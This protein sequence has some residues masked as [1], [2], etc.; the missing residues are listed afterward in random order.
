MVIPRKRR[1]LFAIIALFS[2]AAVALLALV[3]FLRIEHGLELTLPAPDGPFA[4]SRA[5]AVWSDKNQRDPFTQVEGSQRELA[6]WMWYPSVPQPESRKPTEYL[7]PDWSRAFS[8][9]RGPVLGTLLRDPAKVKTHSTEDGPL[10]PEQPTYPVVV[11]R[12]GLGAPTT[13]YTTLAENLASHGY[14]VV[15]FDA[16][17][18]SSL[19][20]FP[21]GRVID[22]PTELNPENF[23]GQAQDRLLV[24]LVAAW[25]SDVA[26]I[27]DRLEILNS[28]PGRFQG[29]L[30]LQ[31]LGVM[32]H[33]LGGA[34][35]A[36]FCHDD[37]RCRSGINLDGA[38]QGSVVQ[39]GLRQ[40]FLQLLSDHGDEQDATSQEIRADLQ[41]LF[42]RS[43]PGGRL[44][45]VIRGANHFTF[46]DQMVVRSRLL[47]TLLRFAGVLRLEPRRGLAISADRI[48][49]FFDVY[50]KG[51]PATVVTS[52]SADYPELQIDTGSGPTN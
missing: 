14:V 20:V 7:P 2:A 50:L 10:S 16:P 35:A 23:S 18:R 8:E 39:D 5:T 41:T 25:T 12:A 3:L 42:E 51:A 47:M 46:S 28:S 52:P 30:N 15:G 6:V 37:A 48:H 13:D 29:R 24:R 27:V 44:R 17:Y 11:L 26:F 38:P 49:R 4:V 45:I 33:S 34:V 1:L 32:G 43:A 40:P 21:D 36:Q 31:A 19:V 9:Y 22:R